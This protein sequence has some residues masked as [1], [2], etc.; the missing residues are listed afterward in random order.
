MRETASEGVLCYGLERGARRVAQTACRVGSTAPRFIAG[1]DNDLF[2]AATAGIDSV[3]KF[4]RKALAP[5]N[6]KIR[7][8]SELRRQIARKIREVLA[9]TVGSGV[10]WNRELQRT[11]A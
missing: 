4:R 6:V 7:I 1:P 2:P 3:E 5:L 10:W 11:I 9:G 8:S